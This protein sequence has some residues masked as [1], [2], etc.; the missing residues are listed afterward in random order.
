LVGLR[1]LE[2]RTC[3]LWAGCSNLL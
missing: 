2:P 3:R 1:G